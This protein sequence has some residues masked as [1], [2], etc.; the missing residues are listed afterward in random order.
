MWKGGISLL[1]NEDGPIFR[2]YVL[3][4][5][6]EFSVIFSKL[7]QLRQTHWIRNASFYAA[8]NF[9]QNHPP[10]PGHDSKG[11]ETLPPG[12]SPCTKTLPS[13]ENRKSKAPPPGHKVRKFHKCI[14]KL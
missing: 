7:F 13:G 4:D 8:I 14:Y 10:L 1:G 5:Q 3:P 6:P 11:A 12:Q 9:I 2:G